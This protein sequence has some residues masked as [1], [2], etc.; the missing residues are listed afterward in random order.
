MAF[1]SSAAGVVVACSVLCV[2]LIQADAVRASED[3]VRSKRSVSVG[4]PWQGRLVRGWQLGQSKYLRQTGEYVAGGNFHG[5][6]ELVQLL[7]RAARRV[8]FRVPGA[9]LSVG[10]LSKR[11]GG[12][13]SGHRSHENGRD[14]DIAFYLNNAAGKPVEPWSFVNIGR[15]GQG[16]ARNSHLSF[17]DARNW[18]LI[19][20]LVA[21]G[22][23]RVQRI[24]VAREIQAR[25]LAEG[26]R[27]GASSVLIE[28]AKHVMVQPAHGH[29][30]R[31]HFHVRIYCAPA[32]QVM[33]RDKPPFWTWYPGVAPHG[34]GLELLAIGPLR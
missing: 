17:D 12:R 32:D 30:H 13:I 23:A 19:A 2:W 8:A 26:R 14:V 21:D 15:S 4:Y 29:P 9:K 33:C 18:E 22:D 6:W 24:F 28:R 5:T 27:R 3:D 31:N 25:L 11:N 34:S 7:E 10:E 20:K 16:Q 1:R